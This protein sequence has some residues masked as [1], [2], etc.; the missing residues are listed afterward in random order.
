[1]H[2]SSAEFALVTQGQPSSRRG[3]KFSARGSLGAG[4]TRGTVAEQAL[5]P[6]NPP[7]PADPVTQTISLGEWR[8]R[9]SWEALFFDHHVLR[10][11]HAMTTCSTRRL[12]R[13]IKVYGGAIFVFGSIISQYDRE[14][15]SS[16]QPCQLMEVPA[17][18]PNSV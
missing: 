12:E 16:K 18:R 10:I 2:Y 17:T 3:S 14:P 6:A 11:H 8:R 13:F 7:D 1:M 4:S 5:N 15:R 9:P